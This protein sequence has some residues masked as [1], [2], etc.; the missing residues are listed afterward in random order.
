MMSIPVPEP[1]P[2]V[3]F[4]DLLNPVVPR[5]ALATAGDWQEWLAEH[6]G[7]SAWVDGKLQPET[8]YM[9][10]AEPGAVTGGHV[11]SAARRDGLAVWEKVN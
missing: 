8:N 1:L 6:N 11:K 3:T 10:R 9:E 2:A 5:R 4:D 7:R